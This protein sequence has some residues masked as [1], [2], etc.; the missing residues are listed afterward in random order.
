M[1]RV[2]VA[3]IEDGVA[4]PAQPYSLVL[5]DQQAVPELEE[6]IMALLPGQTVET[7]IRLPDDHPDESRRGQ[8]R[9]VRVTLHEVKRQELPALDDGFA[10]EL[11]EFDSLDALRAGIQQDL[12]R[13]AAREADA[14]VRQALLGQVIEANRIPA[15]DTLVHRVL[16][17]LAHMYRVPDEQLEAFE[18][19]FRPVA[20]SQVQ[21]DLALD[22]VIEAQGLRATES[23]ID[24]RVA[25]MA[26]A[27]NV[28]AGEMY[29]TLQKANRLPELERGITEEKAFAFLLQQSTV[30]ETS[31]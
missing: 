12:E 17:G 13:E 30:D 5:G 29:A 24:E 23:E 21:R 8:S 1:V 10:R 28:P 19:Q 27:R 22:A 26:A 4:A 18:A 16:H 14:R 20:V 15:P 7:D 6:R 9:R 25:A 31:T 2:E 3:P 11:G